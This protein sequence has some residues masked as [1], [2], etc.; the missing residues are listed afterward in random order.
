L[1]QRWMSRGPCDRAHGRFA[2]PALTAMT[3]LS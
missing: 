2:A 1:V 3:M